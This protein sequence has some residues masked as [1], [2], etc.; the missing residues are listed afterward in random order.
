MAA[1]GKGKVKGKGIRQR[2]TQEQKDN[3]RR[4]AGLLVLVLAA[5]TLLSVVSYLFTWKEDMS[6]MSHSLHGC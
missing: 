1:K 5:F 3:I 2:L 4:Y 6:Q